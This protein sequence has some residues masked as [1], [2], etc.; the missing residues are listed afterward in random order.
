MV[1]DVSDPERSRNIVRRFTVFWQNRTMLSQ[2]LL[3]MAAI[4]CVAAAIAGVI[5]V[6]DLRREVSAEMAQ[7]L[8]AA[9]QT[10]KQ[11]ADRLSHSYPLTTK[12][13]EI[14]LNFGA[15]YAVDFEIY[16]ADSRLIRRQLSADQSDAYDVPQWFVDLASPKTVRSRVPVVVDGRNVGSVVLIAQLPDDIEDVWDGFLDLAYLTAGLNILVFVLLYFVLSRI[17]GPLKKL[18]EGLRDLEQGNYGVSLPRPSVFEFAAITDRLNALSAHL[19]DARS[20]NFALSRRLITIQDEERKQIAA[21]LHDDLGPHLFGLSA[22]LTALR[23]F[24]E[25]S[26]GRRGKVGECIDEMFGIVGRIGDLNRQLL[27][28]LR[29]MV[30]GKISLS[31]ALIG[32]TAELETYSGGVKVQFDRTGNLAETYGETVDLTIYRSIRE[33]VLNA[34]RHG[35]GKI[36]SVTILEKRESGDG[37]GSPFL[38]I[39]IKDDGQ[40]L[41]PD[42]MPGYGLTGIGERVRALGGAWMIA[43]SKTGG[44]SL[45][46]HLP[47]E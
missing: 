25:S 34:I 18:V 14:P 43:S 23:Q 30:I 16:A 12:L 15:A 20:E 4:Q 10:V 13:E 5:L 11:E 35:M 27:G 6:Y 21:E 19:R 29:P 22:K 7:S 46:I 32:L 42:A 40:G 2:L 31:D 3:A 39:L 26:Y 28:K 47:L 33:A 37:S 44:T 41:P 45:E 36:I 9:E 1:N 24:L 38:S 17:V 8:A